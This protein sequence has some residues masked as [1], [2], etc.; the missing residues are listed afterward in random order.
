MA[1]LKHFGIGQQDFKSF[2][3]HNAEL[4]VGCSRF[5]RRSVA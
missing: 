2:Q 5:E 1:N 3:V 4:Q